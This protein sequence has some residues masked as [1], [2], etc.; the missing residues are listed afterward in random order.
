MISEYMMKPVGENHTA[1]ADEFHPPPLFERP[2]VKTNGRVL[3]VDDQ[4]SLRTL[5]LAILSNMGY[6]GIAFGNSGEALNHFRKESFD[7]VLTDLEMPGMD[8]LTLA[9]SIKDRSPETPVILVTG[10]KVE[11]FQQKMRPGCI[12]SLIPKPFRLEGFKKTIKGMLKNKSRIANTPEPVA[13][14]GSL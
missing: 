13:S 12:D 9:Q 2:G 8:G 10:R 1:G 6:Q 3:V 5:F 7:L 4:E 14:H 11:D